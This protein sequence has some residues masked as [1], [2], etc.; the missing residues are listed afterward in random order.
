L[1]GILAFARL[2][3]ARRGQRRAVPAEPAAGR[4]RLF[5][6]SRQRARAVGT[7]PEIA[8]ALVPFQQ[9]RNR[10]LAHAANL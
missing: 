8:A 5:A 10:T 4:A 2:R 7:A 9:G 6:V 3:F 1:I